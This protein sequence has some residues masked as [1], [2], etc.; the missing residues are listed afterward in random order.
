MTLFTAMLLCQAGAALAQGTPT[1]AQASAIRSACRTDY[2]AHCADVPTGGAAAPSSSPPAASAP[3]Q[4]RH[5]L[6]EACD[7]DFQTS[8]PGVRPG[9]GRGIACLHAHGPDLSPDC[10]QALQRFRQSH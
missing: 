1:Q 5:A 9:G 10:Q 3:G 8:C 6:R 4:P 7:A 2:Q